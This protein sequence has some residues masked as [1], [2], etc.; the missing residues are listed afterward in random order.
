MV[1]MKTGTDAIRG[2][3]RNRTAH[4]GLGKLA[5][6]LHLSLSLLDDF[7]YHGGRLPPEALR[8]LATDLFSGHAEFDADLDLLRSTN[9]APA[10]PGGIRPPSVSDKSG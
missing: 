10:I 2:A 3:M 8:L 6:D 1:D 4:G 7:V 5:S 9:R